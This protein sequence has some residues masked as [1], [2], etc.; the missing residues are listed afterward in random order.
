MYMDIVIVSHVTISML[1]LQAGGRRQW[2]PARAEP[3]AARRRLVT[4]SV[5]IHIY[6]YIYVYIHI[7]NMCIYIYICILLPIENSNRLR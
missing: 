1:V 5:Y 2:A 4:W 7:R 3:P 6:I